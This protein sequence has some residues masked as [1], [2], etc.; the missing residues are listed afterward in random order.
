MKRSDCIHDGNEK[1]QKKPNTKGERKFNEGETVAGQFASVIRTDPDLHENTQTQEDPI[2]S[3]DDWYR[4]PRRNPGGFV[5][6]QHENSNNSPSHLAADTPTKT[7]RKC[8]QDDESVTQEVKLQNTPEVTNR[9]NI[10]S[11]L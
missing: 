1:P 3:H 4:L 7:L 2:L 6:N 11:T 9:I 10:Y 5:W 8:S